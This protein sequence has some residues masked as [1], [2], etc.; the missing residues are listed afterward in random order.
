MT[1]ASQV[2]VTVPGTD[3]QATAAEIRATNDA[4][5]VV[6]DQFEELFAL[7]HPALAVSD[8]CRRS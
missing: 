1:V 6:V 5:V 8:L 2:V 4:A 7:G 3:P